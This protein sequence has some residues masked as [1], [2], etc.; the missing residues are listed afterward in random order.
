M[1]NRNRDNDR[2]VLVLAYYSFLDPVFQSAVLPYF[3]EVQKSKGIKIVLLTFEDDRFPMN[4]NERSIYIDDLKKR[5][6]KWKRLKWH[7]GRFKKVKKIYDLIVTMVF[8]IILIIRYKIDVIFSEGFP[9]AL[10]GYFLCLITYRPHIVHTYEPHADYMLEA[11][12]WSTNSWEFKL[13][14]YGERIVGRSASQIITGT[15]AYKS[16]AQE[17]C[18]S[19]EK[20]HVIPSC[21]DLRKFYRDEEQRQQLRTQFGILEGEVVLVY[22]GKFGGMYMEDEFFSFLK[23]CEKKTEYSFKYW[24]FTG[25]DHSFISNRLNESAIPREKIRLERISADDVSKNLSACDIGIVAIRPIPSRRYSS[26]I[27]TGEYWACGLPIVIPRGIGDDFEIVENEG[28]G[29][30]VEELKES[31]IDWTILMKTANELPIRHA[32]KYRSLESGVKKFREILI[33]N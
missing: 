7:S 15:E 2:V 14:K 22:L 8:G 10:L 27:K 26:P 33:K 28:G 24:I 9:G 16:I 3:K 31:E 1:S 13:L 6:I 25:D 29:V 12:V 5:G 4:H 20:I 11:G 19:S 23:D 21:I 18:G 30:V 17:W 32:Q